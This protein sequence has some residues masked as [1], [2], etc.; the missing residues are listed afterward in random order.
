MT[1]QTSVQVLKRLAGPRV[2]PRLHQVL[3][4][5]VYRAG[6]YAG[7]DEISS[8]DLRDICVRLDVPLS[9]R[10][11]ELLAENYGGGRL[12]RVNSLLAGISAAMRKDTS[13]RQRWAAS[14]MNRTSPFLLLLSLA[15]AWD[16][17]AMTTGIDH[18]KYVLCSESV[19]SACWSWASKM[20]WI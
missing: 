17:L 19:W 4:Q 14:I 3:Q 20:S 2:Y 15:S 10:E 8:D 6:N 13:L 12:L 1:D 16:N 11:L 5:K 7:S 18:S 9:I